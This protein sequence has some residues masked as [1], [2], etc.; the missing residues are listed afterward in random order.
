[1]FYTTLQSPVGELYI[2]EESGKIVFI[3]FEKANVENGREKQT[4]LL[5]LAERQLT[6]YFDGA[7]KTFDLPLNPSGT[8][9]YQRVWKALEEIPYGETR[10]Y[11]QIAEAVGAPK[12][13]RAVGGA[14]HNN[15][16]VIVL[17]CHRVIGAEGKLTGYGGAMPVRLLPCGMPLRTRRTR[18]RPAVSRAGESSPA[19]ARPG[20]STARAWKNRAS[21]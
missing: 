18:A 20:R 7:R 10:S 9:F 21:S 2:A 6:E 4:P 15:P 13:C 1:M 3:S 8:E 17:P 19:A 12:A 5:S 14:N 11:K 16:I